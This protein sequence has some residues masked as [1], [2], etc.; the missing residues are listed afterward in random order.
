MK[1][2]RLME[3]LVLKLLQRKSEWVCLKT[4]KG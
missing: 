3:N 4:D 2:Q 1:K